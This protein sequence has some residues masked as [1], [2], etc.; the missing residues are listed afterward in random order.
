MTELGFP[1]GLDGAVGLS[2]L[3]KGVGIG[4][5]FCQIL[6]ARQGE[7]SQY[8]AGT[9]L[10]EFLELGKG[11]ALRQGIVHQNVIFARLDGARESGLAHQALQAGSGRPID[12]AA[13]DGVGLDQV[14]RRERA[15]AT[16]PGRPAPGAACSA[17]SGTPGPPRRDRVRRADGVD[18]LLRRLPS[19]GPHRT[20]VSG[21]AAA[22]RC[23]KSTLL[24][25]AGVQ[26]RE[27][28][29]SENDRWS[30]DVYS[31]R[32]AFE[33]VAQ[34][35]RHYRYVYKLYYVRT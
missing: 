1:P 23:Q 11:A 19:A 4:F 20:A 5:D 29:P 13:R 21:R 27:L 9:Q 12:R 33:R 28:E 16:A 8:L 17:G 31:G 18:K 3:G 26:R 6:R 10:N 32:K 15:H 25:R 24:R 35:M 30:V 34:V 14:A 2:E 22:N 7:R